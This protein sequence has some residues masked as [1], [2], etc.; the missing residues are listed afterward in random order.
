MTITKNQLRGSFYTSD[1][2]NRSRY[3]GDIAKVGPNA[4]V[5][6]SFVEYS[7]RRVEWMSAP[8]PASAF[9]K[10]RKFAGVV[11]YTAA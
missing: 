11:E 6:V 7:V 9:R 8:F 10:V 1:D 4:Y 5:I 3:V 2:A